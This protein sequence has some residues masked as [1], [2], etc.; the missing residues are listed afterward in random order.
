MS[1]ESVIT[2]D[3]LV[4]Q[5]N[6]P[7][8]IENPAGIID[9]LERVARREVGRACADVI[10]GLVGDSEA[11]YRIRR[12]HL[13]LWVDTQSMSEAEIAGR[14]GALLARAVVDAITRGG[15]REVIRF[16]SPRQFVRA[17]LCDLAAGRAW[18]SWVYDEF[19]AL[20]PIPAHDIALHLLLPRPE[21][22]AL[23]LLDLNAREY[24]I[25]Q[26]TADDIARLWSALGP[27]VLAYHPAHLAALAEAWP[28]AALSSDSSANARAQNKLRLWLAVAAGN[29]P[30]ARDPLLLGLVAALVD[31]AALIRTEPEV[32]PLLAMQTPFYPSLVARLCVGA[33]ADMMDWL[34][35]ADRKLVGEL[36]ELAQTRRAEVTALTSAAGSVFLLLPALVEMNIWEIWSQE[37][38]EERA[39]DCLF[40]LALKALGHDRAPLLL[41]DPL[42]ARFAGLDVPPT[43]DARIPTDEDRLVSWSHMLPDLAA[44]R[45]GEV[46]H[47][48]LEAEGHDPY[49]QLGQRLGYP[50]LTPSLDRALS[51]VVVIALWRT[52]ARLPGFARSSAVYTAR[53]FLAQ[54]A[55]VRLVD[56]VL[57]VRLS[58]GPLAIVLRVAGFPWEVKAGWLARPVRLVLGPE[59]GA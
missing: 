2:I 3:R 49:F 11:V 25:E 43:A 59:S 52:A 30:D 56:E 26:W 19:R 13:D 12:L 24:F 23:V 10:A 37:M 31:V 55:N 57:E 58:G 16:D 9:G 39:R 44:K 50:W 38:G 17:F 4:C 5:F 27:P 42:L 7:A 18:S 47:D 32:A 22:I 15:S 33:L 21:W 41:G 35:T 40:A 53:Q 45:G 36:A 51:A 29:P 34:P 46:D 8:G 14:W 28:R 54:P 20:K 1:S 6:V 48:R